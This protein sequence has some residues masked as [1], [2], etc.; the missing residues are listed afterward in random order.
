MVT[1]E[2]VKIMLDDKI[3]NTIIL[4]LNN[5]TVNNFQKIKVIKNLINDRNK[6]SIQ[7]FVN[8]YKKE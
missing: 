8:K 4:I 7:E 3:F 2:S 5:I 1:K 6:L